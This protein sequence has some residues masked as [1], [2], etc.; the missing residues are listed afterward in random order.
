MPSLLFSPILPCL[1]EH[2]DVAYVLHAVTDIMELVMN[3]DASPDSPL[4]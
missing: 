4:S 1:D 2:S 3:K